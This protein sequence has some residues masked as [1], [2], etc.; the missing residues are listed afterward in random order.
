MVHHPQN[1]SSSYQEK[2][3]AISV[4]T[5][6][7]SYLRIWILMTS[8]LSTIYPCTYT[9]SIREK[10]TKHEDLG[11]ESYQEWL[12]QPTIQFLFTRH[13]SPIFRNYSSNTSSSHVGDGG[14]YVEVGM[15][16]FL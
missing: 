13:A 3:T 5:K 15:D 1:L 9:M 11:E 14:N 8:D 4:L 12:N 6:M 10:T 16:D 2:N 7:D